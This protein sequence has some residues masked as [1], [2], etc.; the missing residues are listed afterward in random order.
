LEDK[1]NEPPPDNG[2]LFLVILEP[3]PNPALTPSMLNPLSLMSMLM[4]A[5]SLEVLPRTL[6]PMPAAR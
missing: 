6:A 1:T 5:A 2:K 4:I 3:S